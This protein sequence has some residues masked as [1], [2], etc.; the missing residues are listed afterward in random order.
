[1]Q[2]QLD[3][4]LSSGLSLHAFAKFMEVTQPSLQAMPA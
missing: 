4:I 3:E 2:A 1:M